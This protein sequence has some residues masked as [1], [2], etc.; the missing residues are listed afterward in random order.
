MQVMSKTTTVKVSPL[1]AKPLRHAGQSTQ[2]MLDTLVDEKM[3]GY[4]MV[5]M[6][7]IIMLIYDW[8]LY[9]HPMTRRPVIVTLL[10]LLAVVYCVYKIF[11][12]RL[13]IKNLKL[14]RDDEK[15][16][17]QFLEQLR[18]DGCIVFHDIVG[19]KFNLDH[20]VLSP[21]GIYV[22][23]TKT[24]SKPKGKEARVYYDGT[25]LNID[26]VGNK[27]DILIQVEAATSWLKETLKESTGKDFAIKPVVV[28]PGW[29]VESNNHN[30]HW[31]INP[32]GL[33][34]FI[35][36][37]KEILSKEDVRL[38][39]YHLSRYIRTL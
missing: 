10:S 34:K 12:L 14:G 19:N 32:K 35:Q 39:A 4:F 11:Q 29:Y 26:S 25:H 37:Q 27:D 33:P 24:Y 18:Q 16:V 22:I 3:M 9:F 6:M 38:A 13:D 23:E 15:A 8:W 21:K 28:F 7:L 36:S 5:A 30:K 17:G 1:K 2:E 20:V 31:I